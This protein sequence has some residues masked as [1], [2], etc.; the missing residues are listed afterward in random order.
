LQETR[1]VWAEAGEALSFS[2]MTALAGKEGA[3]QSFIEPNDPLFSTPGD[4]P[5]RIAEYCRSS[6]QRVPETKGAILRTILDSLAKS[7]ASTLQELEEITG[8]RI[9]K[10]HMV[11]GGIQNKL[12]CQL[13]A[14]A[15]GREIIAGPV[16]ASALGN[17]LVQLA[18]LGELDF[19]RAA[20]VVGASET[21]TVYRPN[22]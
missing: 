10:V 19:S 6:G 12:L 20:E 4:M 1:R 17:L 7:Y 21:L 11:G 9:R 13:T 5:G 8:T 2:E 16:E 18:A 14:D 22:K 3:A 15:S